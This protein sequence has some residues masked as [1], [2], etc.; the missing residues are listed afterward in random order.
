[1]RVP[2]VETFSFRINRKWWRKKR[3]KKKLF[4]CTY[5]RRIEKLAIRIYPFILFFCCSISIMHCCMYL[6]KM[7][8]KNNIDSILHIPF[9]LFLSFFFF[10]H[11]FLIPYS[12]PFVLYGMKQCAHGKSAKQRLFSVNKHGSSLSFCLSL[13]LLLDVFE[14]LNASSL[15]ICMP[16]MLRDQLKHILARVCV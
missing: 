12:I 3:K 8:Q 4:K 9:C 5:Q 6:D 7:V 2:N 11:S 14:F 10:F 16:L 15:S 13:S 1:M